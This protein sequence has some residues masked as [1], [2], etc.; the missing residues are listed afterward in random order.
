MHLSTP[1]RAIRETQTGRSHQRILVKVKT[2]LGTG[3]ARH[4]QSSPID[5]LAAIMNVTTP[6]MQNRSRGPKKRTLILIA[7]RMVCR[8]GYFG[9][10]FDI[11]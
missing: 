8:L 10:A 5:W 3:P 11:C 4:S 9:W 2:V 7:E 1:Q 6:R